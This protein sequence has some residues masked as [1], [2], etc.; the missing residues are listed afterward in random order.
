MKSS[1]LVLLAIITLI[2]APHI[3]SSQEQRTFNQNAS[4]SNHTR[5]SFSV[6]PVYSTPVSNNRDSLLFRGN[7]AGLKVGADYFWGSVGIGLNS[8]FT[9]ST[10]DPTRINTFLK[11]SSLPGDQFDISRARQQNMYLLLGPT[12]RFGDR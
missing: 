9:T 4:R 3:S 7:G 12:V 10:S 5:L 6:T 2:C 8:G 1:Y 11:Q